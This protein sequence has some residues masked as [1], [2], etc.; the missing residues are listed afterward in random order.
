MFVADLD[1][2]NV[3]KK[4]MRFCQAAID[5]LQSEHKLEHGTLKQGIGVEVT[6]VMRQMEPQ[7]NMEFFTQMGRLTLRIEK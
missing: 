4:L 5:V 7:K 6:E 2:T 3:N 1:E